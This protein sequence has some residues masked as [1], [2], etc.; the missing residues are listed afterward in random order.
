[1]DPLFLI[2]FPAA[3]KTTV[4]RHLAARLARRF[5]DLDD[6]IAEEAG[7][8]VPALVA[9]D[10]ATFRKIEAAALRYVIDD[11][12]RRG[13]APIVATGGGA[14][15]YGTNLERMRAAGL[16][17]TLAI[18]PK[19]AVARAGD[20][21]TRPLLAKP[22]RAVVELAESREP[23]YRRA[24]AVVDASASSASAMTSPRSPPST[25]GSARSAT[26]RP[27]S[28]SASAAIPSASSPRS[29][30]RCSLTAPPGAR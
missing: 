4:G 23:F 19:T 16:V 14:A 26:P 1:M 12:D 22:L 30:R 29:S 13:D 9:R 5:V 28:R 3:G 27:W 11:A 8:P 24:H 7:E 20:P 25:S 21:A 17:V 15:A 10:Q 2:G 18:E 6:V